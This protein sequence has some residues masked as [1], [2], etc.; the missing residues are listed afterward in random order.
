M[1]TLGKTMR[2]TTTLLAT[3]ALAP[4]LLMA[5]AS[6]QEPGPECTAGGVVCFEGNKVTVRVSAGH[7]D[8]AVDAGPGQVVVG[9]VELGRWPGRSWAVEAG[10]GYSGTVSYVGVN[11]PASFHVE[12]AAPVV[13][14]VTMG[15]SI[16]LFMMHPAPANGSTI[17]LGA[18]GTP[19]H[20]DDF[21]V[22]GDL[23]WIGDMSADID[24]DLAAETLSVV[25]PGDTAAVPSTVRGVEEL[26]VAG[27]SVTVRGTDSYDDIDVVACQAEV[28]GRGARDH[29]ATG[30]EG[31]HA[32]WITECDPSVTIR[33]GSGNDFMTSGGGGEHVF[34]GGPGHDSLSGSSGDDLLRG[35]PGRDTLHGY[36]GNDV[37]VG[38]AGKDRLNA[39]RGRDVLEGGAGHD[40]LKGARGQDVLR[41]GTGDDQLF[42]G[43]GRDFGDGGPGLD[44]CLGVEEAQSCRRA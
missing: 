28:D 21:G 37:L 17:D 24:V 26:E 5:P 35:G 34:I 44:R 20:Y 22:Q 31:W 41:G 32:T 43:R 39:G 23:L 9:G 12:S 25:R 42:G 40:R 4:A 10:E 30:T 6:A 15:S 19:G 7:G 14:N 13:V 11:Q 27:D 16:D 18:G 1:K 29:L 36:D 3:G 33:G 38:G 8:V 2:R